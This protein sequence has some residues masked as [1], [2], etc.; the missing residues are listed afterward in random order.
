MRSSGESVPNHMSRSLRSI[1]SLATKLQRLSVVNEQWVVQKTFH[2]YR[3]VPKWVANYA[4]DLFQTSSK[5][6]VMS[7]I[8]SH[9]SADYL[10]VPKGGD[11]TWIEVGSHFPPGNTPIWHVPTA[12]INYRTDDY[13]S[14]LWAARVDQIIQRRLDRKGIVFTVSYERARMLLSKSRFK[15]IAVT[16]GTSDV[17]QVVERFKNMPAPAVLIS[18]SVT[19]GYDFPAELYNIRYIIVGKIPYPDTKDP[20]TQARQEEDKSWTSFIAMETMVQECGRATR[21][22]TDKCEVLVIDDNWKWFA[23]RY[24]D[25]APAWFRSRIKGSLQSVPDPLV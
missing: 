12:R 4:A 1:K 7:A 20:V 17:M 19:T 23:Y 16:H 21:S 9:R 2:G 22:A 3:F 11:R 13:G 14:T 18:P 24:K 5:V 8:L 15:D 25:F 6:V 10:G